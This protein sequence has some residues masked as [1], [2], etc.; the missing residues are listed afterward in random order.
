MV[1]C[2][3][4]GRISSYSALQRNAG[5]GHQPATSCSTRRLH[6]HF[7]GGAGARCRQHLPYLPRRIPSG[8][9]S[10]SSRAG[11]PTLT[12]HHTVYPWFLYAQRAIRLPYHVAT[13]SRT[14][15]LRLLK[16]EEKDY[17]CAR[18]TAFTRR[19][20]FYPIAYRTAAP[21]ASTHGF[22]VWTLRFRFRHFVLLSGTRV[23]PR[24]SLAIWKAN[25]RR[26]NWANDAFHT[27]TASL[28]SCWV[29]CNNGLF[30]LRCA[31]AWA[32]TAR[33]R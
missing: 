26:D 8:G 3:G 5:R 25:A 9:G 13:G 31:L 24:A 15:A 18:G 16:R 2:T 33:R 1:A 22:A 11:T 28:P 29:G 21:A 6:T 32:A 27:T 12:R 4:H 10:P 20:W 14:A 7:T 19:A 30:P 17:R 23:R